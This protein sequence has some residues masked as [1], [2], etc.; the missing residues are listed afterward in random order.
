MLLSILAGLPWND[1]GVRFSGIKKGQN[2]TGKC[3]SCGKVVSR[4]D[5][6]GVEVD[7]GVGSVRRRALT[8]NCPSCQAVLGCEIDPIALR[9]EI[10]AQTVSELLKRLA[11]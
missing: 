2:M 4:L 3:P 7:F 11:K 8:Y 5:G 9:T 1:I 6:D 10:V